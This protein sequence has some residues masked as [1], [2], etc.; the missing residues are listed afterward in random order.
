[1]GSSHEDD[2]IELS[3]ATL[4][5][6]LINGTQPYI[7]ILVTDSQLVLQ[8]GERV[9]NAAEGSPGYSRKVRGPEY[10]NFSVVLRM[11]YYEILTSKM[12]VVALRSFVAEVDL[13]ISLSETDIVCEARK[14]GKEVKRLDLKHPSNWEPKVDAVLIVSY[15][16]KAKQIHAIVNGQSQDDGVSCDI[17][18]VHAEDLVPTEIPKE[19]D[20]PVYRQFLF[21]YSR[22]LSSRDCNSF[23]ELELQKDGNWKSPDGTLLVS[24][25]ENEDDRR[26]FPI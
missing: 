26:V 17:G 13:L 25:E 20:Y 9:L 5:Q 15:S 8:V 1:M 3:L 4:N 12:T 23:L 14:G 10:G 18:W 19:K 16:S 2:D 6:M 24:V 21:T 11:G 22:L 7:P